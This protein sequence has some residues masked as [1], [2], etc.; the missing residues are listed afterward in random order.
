MVSDTKRIF[1]LVADNYWNE[2]AGTSEGEGSLGGEVQ[3]LLPDE[4]ESLTAESQRERS[5]E[6]MKESASAQSRS[7]EWV[8]SNQY[9]RTDSIFW[10]D[11]K[12]VTVLHGSS[13]PYANDRLT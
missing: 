3:R 8:I 5:N 11:W 6:G 1:P 9:Y 12:S 4:G 2:I 10:K 7:A 13:S